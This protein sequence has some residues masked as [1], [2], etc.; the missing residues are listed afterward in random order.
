MPTPASEVK[1]IRL[2]LSMY[3]FFRGITSLRLGYSTRLA[4]LWAIGFLFPYSR[5]L[6]YHAP[7]DLNKLPCCVLI[8]WFLHCLK[9]Q[10][11]VV[12]CC[13]QRDDQAKHPSRASPSDIADACPA[14]IPEWDQ[15]YAT[16]CSDP[17]PSFP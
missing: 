8:K 5:Y 9:T 17:R 4:S 7:C 2:S 14:G 15:K 16:V 10:P 3:S 13:S 12:V 6:T 11:C 1:P